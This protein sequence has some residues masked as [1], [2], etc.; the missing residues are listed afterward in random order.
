MPHIALTPEDAYQFTVPAGGRSTF[1][2]NCGADKTFA[3]LPERKYQFDYT[4]KY[5]QT[6]A[7]GLK[8]VFVP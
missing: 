7:Y 6:G 5:G 2:G 8:V 4:S 1:L 3:A